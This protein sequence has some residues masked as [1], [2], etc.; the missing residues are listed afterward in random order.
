MSQQGKLLVLLTLVCITNLLQAT[1]LPA[2]AQVTEG[3]SMLR[4]SPDG[5]F[6][7]SVSKNGMIHIWNALTNEIELE[8]TSQDGVIEYVSWSPDSQRLAT[9]S[10]S[11]GLVQI[12]DT[13]SGNMI[14]EL[15]MDRGYMGGAI[16]EWNSSGSTLVG[17]SFNTD[18]GLPLQ[19]WRIMGGR[20]Q[21]YA[22]FPQIAAF[23]I[24]WHPD[25]TQLAVADYRDVLIFDHL[26]DEVLEPRK[27]FP[28]QYTFAWSPDGD[29]LAT[30]GLNGEIQVLN[31]AS[32]ETLITIR[33]SITSEQD[34]TAS[35]AW[36]IDGIRLIT[37]HFNGITQIWDATTGVWLETISLE[38]QGGRNLMTLS[39]SGDRLALGTSVHSVI[40]TESPLLNVQQIQVLGEGLIQIVDLSDG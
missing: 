21:P 17:V 20:F 30:T 27:I 8:I 24:A 33:P 26:S 34:R 12:W 19:F 37:D 2:Q 4:W 18:G 10:S 7:A 22:I 15:S 29:K 38:R 32:G 39:P 36:Q 11:N 16:V 5:K 6:L 14:T 13:A 31:S 23:D 28:F 40:Q 9:A 3:L 25:G 35:I 1:H